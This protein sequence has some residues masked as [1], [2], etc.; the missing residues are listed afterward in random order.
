MLILCPRREIFENIEKTGYAGETTELA[1]R[2]LFL[3][4]RL[5]HYDQPQHNRGPGGRRALPSTSIRSY[6]TR[7][8]PL[9][10]SE[11]PYFVLRSSKWSSTFFARP[12]SGCPICHPGSPPI[13]I[14]RK[15]V[16]S[17]GTF[18]IWTMAACALGCSVIRYAHFLPSVPYSF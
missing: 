5:L 9:S 8:S 15:Y 14:S 18:F 4:T 1:K 12:V 10:S 16:A 13:L 11:I 17:S 6:P 7:S 2:L 3:E